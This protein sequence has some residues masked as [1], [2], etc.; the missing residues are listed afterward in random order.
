LLL[1]PFNAPF[2]IVHLVPT[3]KDREAR[4]KQREKGREMETES[5]CEEAQPEVALGEEKEKGIRRKVKR[6]QKSKKCRLVRYDDLPDYMKDNEFIL[7]YYRCEWPITNA[8]SSLFSWHNE[9]LNIW[10]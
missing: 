1:T 3:I 9:T 5:R 7:N 10:T 6:E 2:S 4:D 8:F